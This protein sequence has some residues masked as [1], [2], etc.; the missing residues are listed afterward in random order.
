MYISRINLT[1]IHICFV[2]TSAVG[3]PPVTMAAAGLFA[4]KHAVEAARSDA[5]NNDFFPLSE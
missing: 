2:Y 3:E 5:G 1:F 4:I